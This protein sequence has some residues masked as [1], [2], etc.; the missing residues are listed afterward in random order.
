MDEIIN[1]E[2]YQTNIIIP[3]NQAALNNHP[4]LTAFPFI[5]TISTVGSLI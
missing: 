2:W 5:N 3:H 4:T 1:E